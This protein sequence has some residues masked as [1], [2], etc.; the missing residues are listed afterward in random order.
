[1][2]KE[3]ELEVGTRDEE[4]P[5][6]I[7]KDREDAD[8]H[9]TV[10]R[11]PKPNQQAFVEHKEEKRMD[12]KKRDHMPAPSPARQQKKEKK[13]KRDNTVQVTVHIN[14]KPELSWRLNKKTRIGKLRA[15]IV[16]KFPFKFHL[17]HGVTV[18]KDYTKLEAICGN[19]QQ[20]K[21]KVV[22]IDDPENDLRTMLEFHDDAV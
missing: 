13:R 3:K 18:L 20:L 7:N 2:L 8:G 22:E 12:V 14:G 17:V 1:M 9:P 11:L 15:R 16:K 5:I 6:Q 21:V 19:S 10:A 4:A